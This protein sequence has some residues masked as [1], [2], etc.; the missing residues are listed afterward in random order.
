MLLIFRRLISLSGGKPVIGV[1][2]SGVEVQ[3]VFGARESD[4]EF[5]EGHSPAVTS[6]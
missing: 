5:G 2:G 4:V 1:A 3:E 6:G